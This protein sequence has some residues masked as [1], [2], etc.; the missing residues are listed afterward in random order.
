MYTE[1]L[2]QRSALAAGIPPQVLN[3]ARLFTDGIDMQKSRRALF[4]LSIGAITSTGSI[5]AWLQESSDNFNTDVP[6]ND[7]ASA[8]SNSGGLN[9]TLGPLTTSNKEYTFEVRAGQLTTG[10]RY[11]RLEIKETIGNN[12]LVAVVAHGDE[13]VEKPNNANNATAV[14]TQ[15]VVA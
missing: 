8:F 4:V 3:A 2:T 6:S 14:G 10:K 15:N 12:V 5:S 13:G 11:V 7:A 9:L 1:T